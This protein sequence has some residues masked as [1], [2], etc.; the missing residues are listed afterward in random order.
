MLIPRTLH[1]KLLTER[2]YTAIYHHLD[3]VYFK[4]KH[5]SQLRSIHFDIAVTYV[6]LTHD[7]LM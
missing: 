6:S 3:S 1:F 4:F 2:F 5:T 7:I